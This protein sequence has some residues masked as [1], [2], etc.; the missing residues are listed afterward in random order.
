MKKYKTA[1]VT[2]AQ[3]GIGAAIAKALIDAKINV[4]MNYLD[5]D[6]KV[7]ALIRE[8]TENGVQAK[9]VQANIANRQDT[10]KL[11]DAADEFGGVDYL[12]SNAAIYPRVSLLEMREDEWAQVLSVNLTGCFL[13]VQ[14]AARK[15]IAKGSGG[16]ILTLSSGAAFKGAVNG[17]HYSASKSGLFGL[18]KSAALELAPHNIRANVIA[19]GL[20][21]TDQPRGEFSDTDMDRLWQTLPLAGKTEPSDI[22]DMALFLLSDKARRVT[23]QIIHVNGG[24]LMP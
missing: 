3:K 19:P 13:M 10:E 2:G 8:A 16:S 24:G 12:V 14:A 1:L 7:S 18:T 17:A 4:V 20:V 11:A 6:S 15:M 21:D 22:A 23:G 5:D 9:A